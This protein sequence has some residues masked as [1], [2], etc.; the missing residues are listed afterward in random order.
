[1]IIDKIECPYEKRTQGPILC[2]VREDKPCLH[3]Y[4]RP[5]KGWWSLRGSALECKYAEQQEESEK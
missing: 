5:C 1:M 4:F 2:T 3:Q